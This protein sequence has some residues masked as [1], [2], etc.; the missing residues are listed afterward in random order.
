M[1]FLASVLILMGG[2]ELVSELPDHVLPP[3]ARWG[4]WTL[5]LLACGLASV[6]SPRGRFWQRAM[7]LMAIILFYL[8]YPLLWDTYT[9]LMP[10]E[11]ADFPWQPVFLALN[12]LLPII[13]VSMGPLLKTMRR[14]V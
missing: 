2:S 8:S 9:R 3:L 12:V 10:V 1:W 14:E 13:M 5:M 4:W 6:Y 7:A 11:P